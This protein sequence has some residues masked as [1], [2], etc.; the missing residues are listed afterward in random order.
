MAPRFA[1]LVVG[2]LLALGSGI[3][4]AS[5]DMASVERGKSAFGEQCALCHQVVP[6][7]GGA[8]GPALNG[9]V[10]RRIGAVA[11]F[12]YTK[13]LLGREDTWTEDSLDRFLSDPTGFAKGIR[14]S[15]NVGDADTRKDLIAYLNT[16]K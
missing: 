4:W 2:G 5:T 6:G 10:G 8:Q 14:M 13:G 15:V 16:T 3:A 11:G 1:P 12:D 7:Q 9:V